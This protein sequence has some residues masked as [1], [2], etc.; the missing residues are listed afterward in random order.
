MAAEKFDVVVVGAGIGGLIVACQLAQAG[1]RVVVLE[2]LG[3]AGGRFTAIRQ[4]GTELATGAFHTFPHGN[5]GPM[6]DALRRCGAEVTVPTPKHFGSF[7]VRGEEVVARTFWQAFGV[8]ASCTERAHLVWTVLK[9][10]FVKQSDLSFGDWLV[11]QGLS[12]TGVALFDRFAQFAL[13]ASVFDVPYAEGR[14]VIRRVV[15]HGLPGIPMGGAREVSRQL[16]LACVRHGVEIRRWSVVESL[17]FGDGDGAGKATGTGIGPSIDMGSG[18]STGTGGGAAGQ[19]AGVRVLNRR[20][21]ER[22]EVDA[23]IVVSN[24]GG[25]ATRR[26]VDCAQR[27]GSGEPKPAPRLQP[28]PESPPKAPPQ[29]PLQSSMQPHSQL[30]IATPPATGLKITVLSPQSLIAHD[31]ILFCLDTQRVAGIIQAT[32]VD[33]GLAPP[34]Q[35]LL[36]SH[37]TLPAGADW[38]AEYALGLQDWRHVF[39]DRFDACTVLGCAN[40]NQDWP[41]NWAVQGLDERTQALAH[42]GIWMVGD[43]FKPAGYMMVEGVAKNALDVV[44]AILGRPAG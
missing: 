4:N 23:S 44:A 20:T 30:S 1:K 34:G 11:Q 27:F 17:R 6:A 12:P 21:N 41:V 19:V 24:A 18:T 22:Y 39:G 37:Q 9:S 40:F 33:P 2:Q 26:L 29:P 43:G 10:K 8:F 5:R 3:F 13:S 14:K 36:I 28:Q 16:V 7:H 15:D 35:H 32:N 31:S 38:R 42:N 25:R